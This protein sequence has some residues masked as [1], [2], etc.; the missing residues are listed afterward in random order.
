MGRSVLKL[1]GCQRTQIELKEGVNTIGRGGA[2]R[3]A[4]K[5]VSRKQVV[6]TVGSDGMT[7]RGKKGSFVTR[8]GMF[9]KMTEEDV[10]L[11]RGSFVYLSS[12]CRPLEVVE[13]VES[14]Q[15]ESPV[16]MG[17]TT[18]QQPQPESA[19]DHFERLMA[20]SDP[21]PL[22]SEQ[23]F[24]SREFQPP[25]SRQHRPSRLAFQTPTIKKP[26]PLPTSL[27]DIDFESQVITYNH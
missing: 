8:K 27:M 17:I 14:Q 20:A 15:P 24:S 9:R 4:D 25:N 18:P 22:G 6:I 19:V 23:L 2:T 26:S 13:E 21:Q 1:R 11:D 16:V 7:I 5:S 10:A 3:V 12:T